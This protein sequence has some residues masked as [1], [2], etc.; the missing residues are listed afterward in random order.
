[1]ALIGVGRWPAW[2]ERL[3]ASWHQDVC[4]GQAP[5]QAQQQVGSTSTRRGGHEG[6]EGKQS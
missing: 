5:G 1:M 3:G 2:D 6:K 4:D